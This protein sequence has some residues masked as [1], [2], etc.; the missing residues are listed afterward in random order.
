MVAAKKTQAYSVISTDEIIHNDVIVHGQVISPI[1]DRRKRELCLAFLAGALTGFVLLYMLLLLH[2]FWANTAYSPPPLSPAPDHYLVG[3]PSS[4]YASEPNL[5]SILPLEPP[6]TNGN[7][8]LSIQPNDESN[9]TDVAPDEDAQQQYPSWWTVATNTVTAWFGGSSH[10]TKTSGGGRDWLIDAQTGVVS[11]KLDPSF[12]LGLGPAP[13]VLVPR[14]SD[15]ALIFEQQMQNMQNDHHVV[16]VD[17]VVALGVEPDH[18]FVGL[19]KEHAEH[20]EGFE[21]FDTVVSKFVKPLSVTYEDENFL[22]YNKDYLLDVVSWNI[23][24]DQKVNFIQALD[25]STFTKGGGRDW[26]WNDDGTL[27]PKLN[28]QLVLGKGVSQQGLVIT[29]NDEQA[30]RLAHAQ[31]LANGESVPMDLLTGGHPQGVGAKE[32]K[33]N[34]DGWRYRE[35]VI[36]SDSPIHIKYDGNFILDATEDFALDIAYW[37][38]EENNAVNFVGGDK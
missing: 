10:E 3:V 6:L 18:E 24:E 2:Q 38:L 15:R 30:L 8:T 13:L 37:N 36:V 7:K 9:V 12:R 33:S 29:Q 5:T 20:V 23:V 34:G 17:F 4:S 27:S 32:F 28:R 25:G 16:V 11:S 35:T 19:A 22:I 21:F 14:H 26:I 1:L 31:E